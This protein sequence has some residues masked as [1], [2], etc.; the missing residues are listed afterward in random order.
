MNLQDYLWNYHPWLEN[1]IA[2]YVDRGGANFPKQP[3]GLYVKWKVYLD[4]LAILYVIPDITRV[5]TIIWS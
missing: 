3:A 1:R 5:E 2:Q 4:D